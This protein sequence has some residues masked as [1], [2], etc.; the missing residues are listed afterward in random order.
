[1]GNVILDN[2][3]EEVK[4]ELGDL[5]LYIVFYT[6]IGSETNI[7]YMAV[8]WN[9]ICEKLIHHHPPIY[10]DVVLK[11]EVE[12]KQNWEKLKLNEGKKFVLEFAAKSL[13]ALVKASRIEEKQKE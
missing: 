3:L 5:L 7:F 13:S 11:D 12:I 9:S 6:K 10:S 8:D 4:K 2:D 1:M